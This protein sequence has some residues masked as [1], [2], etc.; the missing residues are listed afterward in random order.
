M[1][2]VA[3]CWLYCWAPHITY[4]SMCIQQCMLAVLRIQQYSG[5]TGDSNS[6]TRLDAHVRYIIYIIYGVYIYVS[7]T[8]T[9]VYAGYSAILT[10]IL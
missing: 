6:S 9:I 2:S 4:S 3:P 7:S 1:C 8:R 5:S 10:L